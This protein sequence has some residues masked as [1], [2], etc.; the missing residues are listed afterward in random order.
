M[1]RGRGRVAVCKDQV[2]I[3]ECLSDLARYKRDA[4]PIAKVRPLLEFLH[5]RYGSWV[6]VAE[7]TGIAPHRLKGWHDGKV[8]AID[9]DHALHL[10]EVVMAHRKVR[11]P[12]GTDDVVRR[13]PSAQEAEAAHREEQR[14]WRAYYRARRRGEDV[15]PPGEKDTSRTKPRRN[16]GGA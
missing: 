13:L 16:L 1:S 15:Q 9:R 4:V 2:D 14:A 6:K 5:N 3:W 8:A 10:V 7:V 12:W 11:D